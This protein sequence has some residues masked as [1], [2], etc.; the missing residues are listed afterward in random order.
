MVINQVFRRSAGCRK[1]LRVILLLGAALPAHAASDWVVL[2][3][4]MPGRHADRASLERKGP[5]VS[6]T[7]IWGPVVNGV[8]GKE[9]T[10]ERMAV[11]CLTGAFGPAQ[12]ASR[13]ERTNLPTQVTR[14]FDEIEHSQYESTR[15]QP[16]HNMM[17]LFDHIMGLACTCPTAGGGSAPT[18]AQIRRT[19][20]QAIAEPMQKTEYR[21]S[22]LR[23]ESE[24][25]AKE[26]I[27]ALESGRTFASVF[28]QYA[29][30][31]DARTFS[32]GDLG[33][34]LES[35]YPVEDVRRF[36]QLRVG[37]FMHTPRKDLSGW[38]IYQLTGKRIIPAP[39]LET[40]RKRI[41]IYL[42]RAQGCGWSA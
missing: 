42:T 4:D 29:N 35:E 27:A 31:L 36:Q 18:E 5:W 15:L 3:P 24:Q 23:V 34:H 21:L 37:E 28:D 17:A 12:F 19:Y 14:S 41:V 26:A 13:D 1:V 8:P 25:T 16:D 38:T 11:N 7:D 9:A 33:A 10:V 30:P 32:H 39:P 20:D 22:L 40:M 2:D 6:F